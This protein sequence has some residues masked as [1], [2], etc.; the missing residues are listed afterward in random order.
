LVQ[1]NGDGEAV[2]HKADWTGYTFPEKMHTI[3][4]K[5]AKTHTAFYAQRA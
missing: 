2:A 3:D 4:P 1:L 5:E